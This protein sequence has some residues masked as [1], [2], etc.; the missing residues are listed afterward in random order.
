M[1]EGRKMTDQQK[2]NCSLYSAKG[3]RR[4]ASRSPTTGTRNPGKA[5]EWRALEPLKEVKR[6]GQKA[7]VLMK[8]YERSSAV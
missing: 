8:I 1:P 3:R 2:L 6:Q 4:E 7:D 5:Q